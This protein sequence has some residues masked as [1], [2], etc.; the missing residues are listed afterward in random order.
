MPVAI[1][2]LL[3][4]E[5]AAAAAVLGRGMRDNPIHERAF[6]PE[7]GR[8]ETA[9]TRLFTAMLASHVAKGTIL[10][11]F[12]GDAMVGVC[13]MVP[14]GRC[15]LT[16]GEKL[17][18]LPTLLTAGGLRSALR[19]LDWA[20]AWATHDHKA[21]H[22]HLGPVGVER[23]LQGKGIGGALLRSFCARMDAERSTAYL[24]TDRHENV[25]IYQHFGFRIVVQDD[26]LGIPNWFMVREAQSATG[27]GL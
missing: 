9:L 1:R 8:R 24:E 22:W 6:G 15:Q 2:P 18:M 25:G 14:P 19:T 11:A 23:P 21:P 26:V 16:L 10:G 17:G 27:G 7:A 12:V 13:S 20:G 4:R 5:T 3:P